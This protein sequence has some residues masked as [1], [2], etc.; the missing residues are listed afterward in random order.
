M[1]AKPGGFLVIVI[2][3]FMAFWFWLFYLIAQTLVVNSNSDY[4]RDVHGSDKGMIV[5]ESHGVERAEACEPWMASRT[6]LGD[7]RSVSVL[8]VDLEASLLS[9]LRRYF[10]DSLHS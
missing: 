1:A 10:C 7:N 8:P 9:V 4:L 3:I 5:A 6:L 2:F